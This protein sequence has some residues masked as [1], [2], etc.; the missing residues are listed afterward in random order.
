MAKEKL[1]IYRLRVEG[2]TI[3]V[4]AVAVKMR[5]KTQGTAS[6]I[7]RAQ[8]ISIA[9]TAK[10]KIGKHKKRPKTTH[11]G[12][13]KKVVA[14]FTAVVPSSLVSKKFSR[15]NLLPSLVITQSGYDYLAGVGK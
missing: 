13:R 10:D 6:L 2:D 9:L 1:D 11:K 7:P 8:L 3:D 5:G 14:L 15:K 12:Q 4:E